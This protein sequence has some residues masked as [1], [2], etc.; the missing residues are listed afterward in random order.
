MIDFALQ[1]ASGASL[2]Y[3]IRLWYRPGLSSA[4][5]KQQ[6]VRNEL[7][8]NNSELESIFRGQTLLRAD[9]STFV[10]RQLISAQPANSPSTEEQAP[11]PVDHEVRNDEAS[12]EA[13]VNVT[14]VQTASKEE[15]AAARVLQRRYQERL[16]RKAPESESPIRS[17]R[18]SI[19]DQLALESQS[20]AFK[21]SFYRPIFLGPLAHALLCADKIQRWVFNSKQRAK[22]QLMKMKT[23]D[24]EDVR[25]RQTKSKCSNLPVS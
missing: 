19:F 3:M 25:A 23:E 13:L 10:P 14:E 20:L 4:P 21:N 16:R 11:A 2:D 7:Y 12:A 22:K 6:N 8:S 24:L 15:H 17:L 5:P 18:R 1:T 9:A